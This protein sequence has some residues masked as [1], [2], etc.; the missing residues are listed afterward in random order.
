MPH[1]TPPLPP[2]SWLVADPRTHLPRPGTPASQVTAVPMT[3]RRWGKASDLARFAAAGDVWRAEQT[4]AVTAAF[5]TAPPPQHLVVGEIGCGRGAAM[6]HIP[7]DLLAAAGAVVMVDSA[8]RAASYSEWVRAAGGRVM[9][10]HPAVRV[11]PLAPLA[12]SGVGVR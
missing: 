10:L 8:D 12:A 11:D 3:V 5:A 2:W 6:K 4:A 1:P 7:R 9:P